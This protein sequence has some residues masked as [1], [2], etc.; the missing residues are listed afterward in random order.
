MSNQLKETIADYGIE[1]SLAAMIDLIEFGGLNELHK[2]VI[3]A[4]LIPAK[5]YIA[6]LDGQQEIVEFTTVEVGNG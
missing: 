1:N 6:V 3:L 5:N 4:Y 2:A